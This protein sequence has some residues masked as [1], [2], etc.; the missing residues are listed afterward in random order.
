MNNTQRF[1]AAIGALCEAFNRSP[2]TATFKAYE[3]GLDGIA[4]ES[5][6]RASKQALRTSKFMP[7]P[8]ELREMAGELKPQNR[9]I[10]AWD[11]F[12]KALKEH[13]YYHSVDFDDKVINATIRN[14]GGWMKC[15][16]EIDSRPLH[17]FDTWFRKEFERVYV[18]LFASGV[19][20]ESIKYLSGYY[21]LENTRNGYEYSDVKLIAT[22]L[23]ALPREVLKIESIV[24]KTALSIGVDKKGK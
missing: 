5:I 7:S 19:G 6:E 24:E 2:T 3:W 20:G 14:L 23:P 21:E 4:I 18:S 12:K 11:A 16:E 1:T 17:E 13:G 8:S 15:A 10:L 9:A 22:G